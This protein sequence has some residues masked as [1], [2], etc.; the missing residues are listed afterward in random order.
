MKVRMTPVHLPSNFV[1]GIFAGPV[2]WECEIASLVTESKPLL[3]VAEAAKVLGMS[4]TVVNE[5]TNDGTL[6]SVLVRNRKRIRRDDVDA[7][8]K[9]GPR[10]TRRKKAA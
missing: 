9:H 5:M 2:A 8:V 4:R 3:S 1:G 10:K 7:F 6:P